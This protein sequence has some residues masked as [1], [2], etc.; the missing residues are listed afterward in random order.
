MKAYIQHKDR[1]N[2][3]L[4]LQA[5]V[6]FTSLKDSVLFVSFPMAQFVPLPKDLSVPLPMVQF[7]PL[8][9]V[10]RLTH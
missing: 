4:I 1:Q 7:V 2:Q 5:L 3:K 10:Q 9:T 6:P 8:P